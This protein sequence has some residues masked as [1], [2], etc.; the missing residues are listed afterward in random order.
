MSE[1]GQHTNAWGVFEA[2]GLVSSI[3]QKTRRATDSWLSRRM[4]FLLRR[5]A[6]FKLGGNPVDTEVLGAR[7]R[8]WPYRNVCEK[9]ILFTPQFFDPTELQALKARL[10][11]NFVFLDIGANIGGYSIF[12]AAHA[13]LGARILAVEPQPDIYARLVYNLRLNPFS[14]VKAVACA[15]ADKEGELTLFVDPENSGESS[16]KIMTGVTMAGSIKVPAKRLLTMLE[17][18]GFTHVDAAKL[19]TEGAE[20]LILD[21]FFKEAP[22]SLW[23]RLLIMER[24]NARWHVDLPALL[25]S[26]GYRV[27]DETK[28]NVIYER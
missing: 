21:T 6:I 11:D 2:K 10:T 4:A 16:V 5:I 15:V 25:A 22:E 20:D 12:V 26:H 7:M 8:L 24:G 1:T 27:V 23:P 17:E 3:L 28:N 19:D 18:E 14:T 13:G 9:R